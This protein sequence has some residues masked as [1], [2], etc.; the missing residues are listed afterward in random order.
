MFLFLGLNKYVIVTKERIKEESF[1]W[2]PV[3]SI[4][5]IFYRWVR[6]L[7][8]NPAFKYYHNYQKKEESSPTF[9]FKTESG[10]S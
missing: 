7:G 8:L 5:K 6:D 10:R 9:A 3:S 2:V 1:Q 4:D